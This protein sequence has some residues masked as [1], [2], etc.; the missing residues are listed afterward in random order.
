MASPVL[1]M[2]TTKLI[3]TNKA[4]LSKKY[5]DKHTAILDDLKALQSFDATRHL[6]SHLIL[7]DDI[8]QM[9][10]CQATPVTDHADEMQCKKAIDDLYRFFAPGYLL[11]IG[12]Q[13]IIPFQRLKNLLS[14]DND[15][16]GFIPSDLPYACDTPYDT[17]PG[18]FI[19]PTRVVGRLPDVP[20]QTD[21]TY[22]QT[23]INTIR[24]AV[25]LPQNEY[26][27]YYSISTFDWQDST[28][29][30][31]K[32]IFG[33]HARLMV[34]PGEET[35]KGGQWTA[36][37]LS[38][39]TH[40]INCHGAINDPAFYGQKAY[41]FP[42]ALRSDGL[43]RKL[44]PGTIV[45]AECCYGGQLFD[46]RKNTDHLISMANSYMLQ[47]ALAFV[48]SSN[49][50]YGPPTGQGLAD[51]LTQ[52]FLINVLNGASTG[53]ALLEARQRFLHEMG[54]TLDPY[55]LKTAAQFYLLGDPSIQPVINERDPSTDGS[56]TFVNSVQN[57]RDNLEARGKVLD[58]FIAVPH[59]SDN[60]HT[61]DPELQTAMDSLLTEKNFVE[62]ALPKVF[63]NRKRN[64]ISQEALNASA[65]SVKFHVFSESAGN[66]NAPLTKVLVVKEKNNQIL[67]YREYVSR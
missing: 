62:K 25:P 11:L 27:N 2:L 21:I 12:A 43:D 66:G 3:I 39:K 14:G 37:Q 64:H 42:L 20:G 15:P 33:D 50:A 63:I 16:D 57:R 29:N 40:F 65:P 1:N 24:K 58:D 55:E 60:S 38:P 6:E 4:A 18:K 47:Q 7:L 9:K 54:P 31:L 49:I 10:N 44:S 5:G 23:L 8:E 13:D 51:L 17:D 34:F 26:K 48:G 53:R 61:T 52:F 32:N 22:L 36:E 35:S 19:A 41:D 59:P 28:Q 30:S 46:P 67:G 45:A 56:N